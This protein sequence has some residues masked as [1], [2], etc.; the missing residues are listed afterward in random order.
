MLSFMTTIYQITDTHVSLVSRNLVLENFLVLMDYIAQHPADLL[1][2]S[3]DLPGEDG[4]PEVYAWMKSQLPAGQKTHV[5]PGNHDN[6]ANLYSVFGAEICGN[7]DFLFTVELEAIDLIFT[8]TGSGSFPAEHLDYI[9]RDHIRDNSVLFTHYPTKTLSAGFMDS[10]YS[11]SNIKEADDAIRQSR[12]NTVF[13]GH[14]H[15][16]HTVKDGY[17]LNITPSPAF[18]VALHEKE[19]RITR[20][21]IPLRKI[22]VSGNSTTSTIVYL[23]K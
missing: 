15:T 1:V 2:I 5:I 9:Q 22:E 10:N 13:C 3:G 4:N 18:C 17:E 23:D 20:A 19:P 7:K 8:N 21:R 14:F 11:L 16:E 12:I 6:A